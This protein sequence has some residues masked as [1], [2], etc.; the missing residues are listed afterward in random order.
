MSRMDN[1]LYIGPYREFSG[2]GNASRAY[3]KA[4]YRSGHNIS[5]RPMYNIYRDYPQEDLGDEILELETNFSKKYHTVIQHCYPH[6][7]HYSKNFDKHIAIIH[8]DA[9]GYKS[10]VTQYLS[11]M[12]KIIVGSKFVEQQ[13]KNLGNFQI[14]IVP[15]PV[16]LDDINLYRKKNTSKNKNLYSFY[17]IG[18]WCSRK[19]FEKII[20]AYIQMSSV[21]DNIELVIKTKSSMLGGT[22]L[23]SSIEYDLAKIYS[24]FKN[25]PAKKP[26]LVVGEITKENMYFIHNNNNC[27]I[28]LS[29]AESFG[30]SVLEGTAFNNNIII[31]NNSSC[32]EIYKNDSSAVLRVDT[33]T[34]QCFDDSKIFPIY[35]S[36]EHYW[37]EP[38]INSIIK[39]M[40][41]AMIE[42]KKSKESRIKIQN[43]IINKYSVENIA[44]IIKL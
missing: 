22:E 38:M 16:D 44:K 26:K 20:I 19:N 21:Y 32:S 42:T 40:T 7:L 1:V 24:F 37:E 29:G 9:Y 14:D 15:E 12:D 11:I 13:L 31:N 5:I 34:A 25:T 36:K 39:N 2:M 41:Q 3:L 18:D 35:N 10:N 28:N 17:C 33:E 8:L 27:L 30:Y 43:E 23:K 6:Q 4:L